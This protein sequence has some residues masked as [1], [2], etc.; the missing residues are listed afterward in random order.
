LQT[1]TPDDLQAAVRHVEAANRGQ[2]PD[3]Y[4]HVTAYKRLI[5]DRMRH[6]PPSIESEPLMTWGI[7]HT[8]AGVGESLPVEVQAI[9]IGDELAIVCLPGEVFVDLGLAIKRASPFRTTLVIELANAY[10]TLYIPTRAAH[11]QGSY[12][13]TNCATQPGSGEMLVEAAIRVL[14]DAAGK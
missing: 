8:W 3:F 4:E 1:F 13:V 11:A 2:P 12:E 14:Q 9:C 6:S 5:I 7:N 10:E